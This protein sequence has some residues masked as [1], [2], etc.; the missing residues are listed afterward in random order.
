VAADKIKIP[1]IAS[2]GFGDGRGL[3]AAHK[4]AAQFC[5]L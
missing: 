3:V 5:G 1:M 4:A 2:G